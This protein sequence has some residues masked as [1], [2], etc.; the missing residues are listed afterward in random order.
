[1]RSRRTVV[2]RPPSAS[3]R[4]RADVDEA[5]DTIVAAELSRGYVVAFRSR[6]TIDEE[7][8]RGFTHSHNDAQDVL[9][10]VGREAAQRR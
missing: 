2:R 4:R 10:A 1:M 7:R 9:A 8:R 6:A 3:C 5:R